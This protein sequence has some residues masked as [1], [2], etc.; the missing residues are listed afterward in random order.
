MPFR[1]ASTISPVIS[2][3][4]SFCAMVASFLV[5]RWEGRRRAAPARRRVLREQVHVRGLRA[6]LALLGL[7]LHLRTF[8]QR[9]IA[10]ALNGAEVDEQVL[11]TLIRG[12]EPITL[13]RVEPLDGSGCHMSFTSLPTHS[14]G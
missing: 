10:A 5:R 14:T 13:V 3:L 8:V 1:S 12:D 2:T 4:S 6:L 11:A 9:A 7:V